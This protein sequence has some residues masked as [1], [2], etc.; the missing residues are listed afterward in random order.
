MPDHS[1]SFLLITILA[2]VTITLI[3]AM[4]YFSA[5]RIA[6]LS[7]ARNAGLDADLDE[8]KSRL[9]TIEKVLREVE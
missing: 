4:K 6:R 2:L 8:I 7:T 3:F 5:G 1:G 9:S